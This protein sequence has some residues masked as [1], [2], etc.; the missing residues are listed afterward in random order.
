LLAFADDN[1]VAIL[2]HLA[3]VATSCKGAQNLKQDKLNVS[4][5]LA[6]FQHKHKIQATTRTR[7]LGKTPKK[8]VNSRPTR[9][10]MIVA[11]RHGYIVKSVQD[12]EHSQEKQLW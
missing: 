7:R 1:A 11:I 10:L 6:N 9:G 5:F 4:S 12:K 8:P 2:E 3:L